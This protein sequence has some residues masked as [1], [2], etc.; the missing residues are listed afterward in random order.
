MVK[1]IKRSP[2]YSG[3]VWNVNQESL[4][5]FSETFPEY[6]FELINDK[7]WLKCIYCSKNINS[8]PDIILSV[9]DALIRKDLDGS[10]YAINASDFNSNYH[11]I[12]AEK[13]EIE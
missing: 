4:V 2:I 3:C 8:E 7:K 10:I 5:D 1:I 9:G 12:P 13:K 6:S 11:I